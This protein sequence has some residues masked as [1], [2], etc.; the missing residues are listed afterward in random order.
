MRA[1]G[2]LF[3][4]SLFSSVLAHAG[5]AGEG[6]KP[7]ETIQQYAKR[8]MAMEHHIDEFDL[9]SFHQL[10]DL[11]RDS[12]WDKEEIEAIYGVH[13]IYSVKKSKDDV[14]HQNKADYISGEVLRLLDADKDGRISVEE[15]E[16]VG[17][18]GLPNFDH[19]GAE[20]HHYDVESEFFL[21]HEEEFHSTPETQTDE[22]YNHPEDIEHFAMHEAIE[23]TEAEKEAAYQGI[24]V[25]EALAAHEQAEK[26]YEEKMV[27][28]Q[29]EEVVQQQQEPQV[30]SFDHP[31]AEQV[32]PESPLVEAPKPKV[33][34]VIPPEKQDPAVKFREAKAQADAKGAWGDGS[35][36][37][38]PPVDPGDKMRKNL[39]YKS[40]MQYKF[41]R[42]WGDF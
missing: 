35:D 15:L 1:V 18:D 39:P 41:R 38:L 14:E 12:A 21:H 36:G 5:H 37:Y 30:L 29:Q 22:S 42:N 8:H 4:L 7:G 28:A 11:N 26:L 20:G 32:P 17:L 31:H 3:L 19:M 27:A 13:H 23:H 40:G 33:T 16:S 9:P 6:P 24:T 10:H 2:S 25:E 34:R